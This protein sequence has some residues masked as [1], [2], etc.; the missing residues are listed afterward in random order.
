MPEGESVSMTAVPEAKTLNVVFAGMPWPSLPSHS[1]ASDCS[2]LKAAA[3]C[4]PAQSGAAMAGASTR[5]NE[6][7]RCVTDP[8][9]KKTAQDMM[10]TWPARGQGA[11]RFKGLDAG[12]VGREAR[13]EKT[14][15]PRAKLFLV[16][17]PSKT[18]LA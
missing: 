15:W 3:E 9:R 6:S 8:S 12:I 18:Y 4:A 13:V 16:R 1:P 5:S 7:L 14:D 2:F 17:A 11:P 10:I